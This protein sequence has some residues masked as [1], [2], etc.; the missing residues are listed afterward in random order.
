MKRPAALEVMR[1]PLIYSARLTG[2]YRGYEYMKNRLAVYSFEDK[3]GIADGYAVFFL[4]ELRKSASKTVCVIRGNI[5]DKGREALSGCADEVLEAKGAG[6]DGAAYAFFVNGRQDEIKRYDELILCSSSFFGPLYPLENVFREMDGRK[7]KGDFWG[8]TVSQRINEHIDPY[9]MVFGTKVIG[10]SA[11]AGFFSRY[12]EIPTSIEDRLFGIE[13][14]DA[15]SMAGFSYSSL[16]GSGVHPDSTVLYPDLLVREHSFPFVMKEAFTSDYAPFFEVGRGQNA[17]KCLQYIKDHTSYDTGLVWQHL[18]RTQKMSVLRQNLNLNYIIPSSGSCE[19]A[20]RIG[21][22]AVVCYVYYKE[23]IEECLSY[24]RNAAGLADLYF[25]AGSFET[26]DAARKVLEGSGFSKVEYIRKKN[27][28]RDVSAYLIDCADLFESYDYLCFVHDKKSPHNENSETTHEFF[29]ACMESMLYSRAYVTNLLRIFEDNPRLGVAVMP[30]LIF[31][32]FYSNEYQLNPGNVSNINELI[33]TLGL[34]VPFDEKPVAAYGDMFWC[35]TVAMRKLFGRK[36]SYDDLPGEPVP[37]DGT[38]LHAIERIHPFVAQSS[39]FYAAWVHPDV[40][41]ASFM[42]NLYYID[43]TL[44]DRLFGVY[45]YSNLPKLTAKIGARPEPTVSGKE[46]RG[47][48]ASLRA[49]VLNFRRGKI[50]RQL[51]K[52]KPDLNAF[53][54]DKRRIWDPEY[55]LEKNPDV[56]VAGVPPLGHYISS[57]WLEKRCLSRCYATEDYLIV[58]QDCLSLGVSPLEHYYIFSRERTVFCSYEDIRKYMLEHGAE[59]LK[60]SS[61][62]QPEYYLAEYRKKHG[63]TPDGFDP[64]SYYLENGAFE[65][66]KTCPH[67][68]V[69]SYLDRFPELKVYGIC[70]VVHYEL[71]GKYLGL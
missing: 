39:G 57:G 67:F 49:A 2:V 1:R 6:C 31:S 71:V 10:S 42:N 52:E 53:F 34:G 54:S 41:A 51:R 14:T 24:V 38:I 55:Y 16:V 19:C 68:R 37:D 30:P 58:N 50:R 5:T 8:M 60:K 22:T 18:L 61:M 23:N 15:L 65:S 29:R 48:M 3:N 12:R 28:G 62:F 40:S 9:F 36:W 20:E 64:C 59:I 11:F 33:R 17:G 70:P 26:L 46:G 21:K 44:N 4:K 63:G 45:G 27:K 66:L 7:E 25:V 35:R 69:H 47:L 13:L 43:R 32:R 56:A